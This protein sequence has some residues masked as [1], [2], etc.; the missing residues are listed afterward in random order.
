MNKPKPNGKKILNE[1]VLKRTIQINKE[2]WFNMK[3]QGKDNLSFI[4]LI[5]YSLILLFNFIQTKK[6]KDL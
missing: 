5:L 2:K 1:K 4:F 6:G 3:K